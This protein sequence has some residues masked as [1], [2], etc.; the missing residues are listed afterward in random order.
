MTDAATATTYL[1][2]VASGVI[3]TIALFATALLAFYVIS[4]VTHHSGNRAIDDNS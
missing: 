1:V 3:L 2:G 4:K